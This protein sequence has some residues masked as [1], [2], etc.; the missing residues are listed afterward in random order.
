MSH[1]SVTHESLYKNL[2]MTL[3]MTH[4]SDSLQRLDIYSKVARVTQ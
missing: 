3:Y 1:I 2:Y 4:L